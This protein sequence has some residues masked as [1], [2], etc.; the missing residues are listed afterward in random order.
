MLER[1]VHFAPAFDRCD[2]DPKKNY[3]IRGVELRFVLKGPKGA[4]QFVVY[5]NWQLPHVTEETI[6]KTLAQAALQ[7]PALRM[8]I[9]AGNV[10]EAME[11]LDAAEQFLGERR[12]VLDRATL[13]CF[14]LP[15]AADLGYHSPVPMYD[16]QSPLLETCEYLDGKPC[17]Y[18]GS[19]LYADKIFNEVFL[20]EGSDG[21]WK[22]M[23]AEY[24]KRFEAPDEVPA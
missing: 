12:G 14:F 1:I 9:I 19:T 3:G 11:H 22:R 21:L 6:Q 24:A 16:G 15:M 4:I 7:H 17:Y 10:R 18:D 5:T 23:E 2:P 8:K 13:K 20:P